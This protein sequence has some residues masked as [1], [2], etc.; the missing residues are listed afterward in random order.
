[1]GAFRETFGFDTGEDHARQA[2]L[3]GKCGEIA[4]DPTYH[5]SK[6]VGILRVGAT[7]NVEAFRVDWCWKKVPRNRF[8]LETNTSIYI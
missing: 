4:L 6:V 5:N 2:P 1:M 3:Q 7:K 8:K